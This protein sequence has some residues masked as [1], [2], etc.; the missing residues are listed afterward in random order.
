MTQNEKNNVF[1]EKQMTCHAIVISFLT[2]FHRQASYFDHIPF[3]K[4]LR[5][6]YVKS[7]SIMVVYYRGEKTINMKIYYTASPSLFECM[8]HML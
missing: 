6:I 1:S 5:A 7:K 8:T 3:H 4:C 2:L